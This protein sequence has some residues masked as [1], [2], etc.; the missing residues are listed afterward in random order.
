[1]GVAPKPSPWGR[2]SPCG[3]EGRGW[4]SLVSLPRQG[5]V[6]VVH[7]ANALGDDRDPQREL[8]LDGNMTDVVKQ[9]AERLHVDVGLPLM[10]MAKQC[11]QKLG[12]GQS[13]ERHGGDGTSFA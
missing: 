8:G 1:M 2:Q 10:E 3:V 6:V 13:F 5:V 11:V 12:V 4:G 7:S 9:A